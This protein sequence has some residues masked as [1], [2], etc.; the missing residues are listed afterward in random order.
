MDWLASLPGWLLILVSVALFSAVALG[1][2][3]LLER[4]S[5]DHPR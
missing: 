4:V 5:R 3:R 1:V 2:R